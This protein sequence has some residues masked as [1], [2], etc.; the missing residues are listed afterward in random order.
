[1]NAAFNLTPEKG[2]LYVYFGNISAVS[3]FLDAH[4]WGTVPF[5]S[6]F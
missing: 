3:N 6:D 5:S 2:W 1:M 4:P